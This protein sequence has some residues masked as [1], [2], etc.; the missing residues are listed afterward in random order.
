MKSANEA[1]TKWQTR[2]SSAGSDYA[3]G[4]Q[5]T[6]KDQAA[7]AI[8]AKIIYQQQLT[9]SFARDAFA[10]GLQKSGRAGWL[11]GVTEKGVNN[12]SSG[13]SA[14]SSRS[15][16]ATNSGKYDA[17]RKAA[18]SLPRGGRGSAQNLQ[19]VNAVMTALRA[20]KIGK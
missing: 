11:A 10:K 6:E 17:A 5:S 19:R 15:K 8:A 16:Y 14:E 12:Y 7:R 1:V 18:D 2:A 20:V 3:H 9:E 13:V 4:A